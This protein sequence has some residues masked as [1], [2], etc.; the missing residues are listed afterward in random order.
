MK[1]LASG[2]DIDAALIAAP[3]DLHADISIKCLRAGI[4]VLVEKPPRKKPARGK[5][6]S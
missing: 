2:L 1:C 4:N 3:T 5:N 6:D